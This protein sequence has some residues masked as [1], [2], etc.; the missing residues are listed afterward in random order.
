M[1]YSVEDYYDTEPEPRDREAEAAMWEDEAE[2]RWEQ[3]RDE[4]AWE[5]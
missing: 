2:R 5:D 3:A 1:T 4:K